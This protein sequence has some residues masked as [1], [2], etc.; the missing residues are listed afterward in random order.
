MQKII[1]FYLLF[2]FSFSTLK[3]QD[4]L[5]EDFELGLP[6]N[7]WQVSDKGELGHLIGVEKSK[8]FRFH[9]KYK[10]EKLVTP[11]LNLSGGGYYRLY[12]NWSENGNSNPDSTIISFS[13]DS[14]LN[15]KRMGSFG[16]GNNSL[17]QLDSIELGENGAEASIIKFEYKGSGRFPATYFNIDDIKISKV[18]KPSGIGSINL[19]AKIDLF[20]NPI[21]NHAIL[22]IENVEKKLLQY[23][24]FDISGIVYK[25]NL[26]GNEQF[27]IEHIDFSDL[28]QGIYFVK[29]FDNEAQKT[30]KVILQ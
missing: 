16:G 28:T 22:K 1:T 20:P 15:W 24:I 7:T 30:I 19:N 23:Q 13:I 8:F 5:K 3:A 27:I 9:P 10:N 6:K 21:S 17:W 14:G 26:I 18:E 29:I 2:F 4:I 11:I 25:Q 12:F